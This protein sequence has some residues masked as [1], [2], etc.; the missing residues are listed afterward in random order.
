MVVVNPGTFEIMPETTK[1]V[2][3]E[4]LPL[5]LIERGR[6]AEKKILRWEVASVGD[7]IVKMG[8]VE[9]RKIAELNRARFA[10]FERHLFK[11]VIEIHS[12]KRAG[13]GGE[14]AC[15]T[16]IPAPKSQSGGMTLHRDALNEECGIAKVV[17]G[18]GNGSCMIYICTRSRQAEGKGRAAVRGER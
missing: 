6:S 3:V 14:A 5:H 10:Q 18:R 15:E 4:S 13:L 17:I 7:L 2:G 16:E 12:G 9:R 8:S 1:R 11:L